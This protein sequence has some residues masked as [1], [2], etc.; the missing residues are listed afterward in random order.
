MKARM[1]AASSPEPPLPNSGRFGIV[2]LERRLA[3]FAAEARTAEALDRRAMLARI[4]AEFGAEEAVVLRRGFDRA[5]RR[6]IEGV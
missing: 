2:H 4:C 3:L 5:Y 6:V 1:K